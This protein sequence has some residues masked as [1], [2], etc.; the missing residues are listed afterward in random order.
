[1]ELAI[2]LEKAERAR[3]SRA[4]EIDRNKLPEDPAA[5]RQMVAGLL[6][7]LDTKGAGCNSCST[8]WSSCCLALRP[9]RERVNENQLF[10]YAVGII[11]TGQEI[12]PLPEESETK[13]PHPTSRTWRRRLP[14]PLERRRVVYDL[15]KQDEMSQCQ[16]EL[17]HIGEEVSE[18]LEY[19]PASL[20]VIEEACQKYA[21]G[22]AARWSQR[23]SRCSR[24][25]RSA[26]TG[27]LAHVAVSKYGDHLP[28][29][30]SGRDYHAKEWPY[31]QNHVRL[32]ARCA[33]L[34]VRF[35][36]G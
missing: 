19:V 20:Y 4:M 10:L 35:S 32:D 18:R 13:Q 33:S 28:F 24:S 29:V 16:G 26:G 11:G 23:R 36:S 34:S 15:G 5:L 6:E 9:K 1:V 27:L 30:P 2:E 14:K 31:P 8:W 7:E 21:C 17:Q 22:K 12:L 25:R 3:R